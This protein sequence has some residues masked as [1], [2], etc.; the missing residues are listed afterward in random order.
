M[1]LGRTSSEERHIPGGVRV[2]RSVYN[3]EQPQAG[4]AYVRLASETHALY[5]EINVNRFTLKTINYAYYAY[6]P[7][8]NQ[9][10]A[11]KER[12]ELD[13]ANNPYR[14]TQYEYAQNTTGGNW[15]INYPLR[16]TLYS[17]T[18]VGAK[19]SESLY[20][21]AG[22]ANP[23][24]KALDNRG[25]LTYILRLRNTS[26]N[27]YST[28]K[29][30]YTALGL[31]ESTIT[32]SEGSTTSTYATNTR[33]TTTTTYNTLGL[34]ISVKTAAA[35]VK[36]QTETIAY[37]GTFPWL[38]AKVTDSNAVA[39]QYDYDNFGRLSIVAMPGDSLTINGATI[40]YDYYDD[41]SPLF[42][43]PLLVGVFYKG[44]IKSAERQFYDGLG[45]LVQTQIALAEVEGSGDKDI[46]VTTAYDARGLAV[47]T[48]VPYAVAKYVY[49]GQGSPSPFKTT[50]CTAS[51]LEQTLTIYD[52]LGRPRQVTTPDGATSETAYGVSTSITVDG[53]SKLQ[54]TQ[55][56][57]ANDHRTIR[58]ND[59][60][61][62]LVLVREQTG[63][64]TYTDYADTRY[65]YD[66]MG[67]LTA[68]K[69]SAA[70]NSQPDSYL[71][72]TTMTYDAL[73]RK[74]A[75]SDPDMREWSYIYGSVGNLAR[76]EH[77]S[78]AS[79]YHAT[80]LYYDNLNRLLHRA[81]DDSPANACPANAPT[82]GA[83]HLA[84][85]VYGTSKANQNIGKPV[86]VNWG[87]TPTQNKDTFTYDGEGRLNKQTRTVNNLSF[88][89]EVTAYDALDRPTSVKLPGGEVVVTTYDEEGVD[90]LKAG[91]TTLMNKV[92]Y[93]ER[94]QLVY[95][96]RPG[97]GPETTLSYHGA[98]ENFR[99]SG[100]TTSGDG[101]LPDFSYDNY[102]AVGNLIQFTVGTSSYTYQYDDLN[103]LKT[104]TGAIGRDYAYD[105][106]GNF[107]T[108]TKGSQVWDYTYA[109]GNASRLMSVTN[110][111]LTVD[112]A[113]GY[114]TWGN[115][116]KYTLGGTLYEMNFDAENRL[117]TVKKGT[118]TTAFAYDADGQRVMTTYPDGTK[119]YTPFPD[120]EVTDPPTGSDTVRTT[121]RLAGQIV[122]VQ[123]KTGTAAGTFYYTYTDHLGNLMALS[124]TGG[125]YVTDSR[126]RYDPFG[127]FTTIPTAGNPAISDHGFTGHRH[128]NTGDNDLG[129]I[130][131][132]ARYY[133][134]QVGRFISADTIGITPAPP[135]HTP[136]PPRPSSHSYPPPNR[137]APA[138]GPAV[139]AA[140]PGNPAR[141]R[142]SAGA[143]GR[144]R[145]TGRGR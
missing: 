64:G 9:F 27:E 83:N 47:C 82:T 130:Y 76:Q 128:N 61:G 8:N 25:L 101:N 138:R 132:N 4:V 40:R 68:V 80:C 122:A 129:L 1:L 143:A 54:S 28:E 103:R 75:M 43:S 133:L 77:R 89:Y 41:S 140:S 22:S 71:W 55:V 144:P 48:T 14:C 53:H 2:A 59:I 134:P 73:G 92:G 120:Y 70:N 46:V 135:T 39:T 42:T 3:W 23:T 131:M 21:Y 20:R 87:A 137:R 16:E 60:F 118:E 106:L 33:I 121:Y 44:N 127:T 7:N 6:D 36:T 142:L 95:L 81:N 110:L 63:A 66:G 109:S 45:R 26:T 124:T 5:D 93:N 125:T 32:F 37:D 116:R 99:L 19:M 104:V 85:Y 98:T 35:G 50:A 78:G 10:G 115:M 100:I 67:N 34:P 91:S 72:Q 38:V 11:L 113:A 96:E 119:V 94:G 13:E 141:R 18:C 111:P 49:N 145:A 30:T 107:D 15:L 102:D 51:T 105:R 74:T 117:A 69:K 114:D 123:T 52:A 29:R 12:Q 24:Q 112:S 57:D 97:A 56:T 90:T 65:S 126:A 136:A 84:S 31:L 108:V 62:R 139:L 79:V 17:G 86:E 58:Y 88:V